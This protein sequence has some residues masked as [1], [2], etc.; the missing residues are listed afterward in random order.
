MSQLPRKMKNRS[1]S[2]LHKQ[3]WSGSAA[4]GK[5]E[6]STDENIY[7]RVW[8]IDQ[9][10]H[11]RWNRSLKQAFFEKQDKDLF[12]LR[13]HDEK[14]ATGTN[15]KYWTNLDGEGV[16]SGGYHKLDY[17]P[18]RQTGLH[19]KHGF[20]TGKFE[21]VKH[22]Q[23]IIKTGHY[24]KDGKK[25]ELVLDPRPTFDNRLHDDVMRKNHDRD[26][27]L[28]VC[29]YELMRPTKTLSLPQLGAEFTYR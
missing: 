9:G 28:S 6:N 27:E 4:P 24:G 21:N 14:Y 17:T 1:V 20:Y 15:W 18:Q 11:G 19:L 10:N 23:I 16:K 5:R 26:V 25:Q 2:H 12:A 13:P 29:T 22:K 3:P 8:L 7:H